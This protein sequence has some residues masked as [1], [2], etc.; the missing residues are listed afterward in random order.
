MRFHAF[1]MC[2]HM[3]NIFLQ[4]IC[5]LQSDSEFVFLGPIL[6]QLELYRAHPVR[7]LHNLFTS[8]HGFNFVNLR[9]IMENCAAYRVA[10]VLVTHETAL[11]APRPSQD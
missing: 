7:T 2:I 8:V 3:I 4:P 11:F 1:D 9:E 10:T 5:L 6:K